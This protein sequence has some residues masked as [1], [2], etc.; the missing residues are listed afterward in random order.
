MTTL[1]AHPP[2]CSRDGHPPRPLFLYGSKSRGKGET[3]VFSNHQNGHHPGLSFACLPELTK[4]H[5]EA[6]AATITPTATIPTPLLLLPSKQKTRKNQKLLPLPPPPSTKLK[7]RSDLAQLY[8][9]KQRKRN[10]GMNEKPLSWVGSVYKLFKMCFLPGNNMYLVY[11]P[12]SI[13]RFL[14]W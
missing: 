1:R 10:R 4:T 6:I 12:L 7:V 2:V 9:K 13:C 8:T 5:F 14:I 11:H 3:D